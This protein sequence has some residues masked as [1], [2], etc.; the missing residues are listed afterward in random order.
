MVSEMQVCFAFCL[1]LEPAEVILKDFLQKITTQDNSQFLWW[2]CTS[3]ELES[4]QALLWS[5]DIQL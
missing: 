1:C 5:N 2:T 4:S 3:S